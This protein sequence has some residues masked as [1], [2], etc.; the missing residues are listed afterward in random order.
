MK[1][2]FATEHAKE[3][4][5]HEGLRPPKTLTI[6]ITG[7][8]NLACR[9]CWVEAGEAASAPHVPTQTLR[10]LLEEFAAIGG[11]GV[12]L[13][14]GE[15]LCH[16]DWL[17]LIRLARSI[18]FLSVAL[19][20]NAMLLTDEQVAQLRELDFPGLS[21]QVS[22]DGA[23][24]PSH[25]LVRGDGAFEKAM[26]GI[27]RLAG[28][29]LGRRI[30]IAFT[31]MRHNLEEF[32]ALLELA[33]GLGV[34]SVV[35]GTLITGGRAGETDL[36]APADRDQYLRLLD[37]Y[38][39]D[40]RFRDL[41]D[42]L[43]T[44]AALEWSRGGTP[45]GECCTFVENPYLTPEGRLYPCLLCHTDAYAVAGVFG[46][47]LAAALAEGAPSWAALLRISRSRAE[48]I[49]ECQGCP[50]RL[51]CAGGCMGRAW[52]SCGDLMAADDRC[53]LRQTIYRT[54]KTR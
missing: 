46:K 5:R 28:A 2:R 26:A 52:G 36:L 17:E 4:L 34:G 23:E 3:I 21:I 42:A 25:D 32:P 33:A 38:A 7:V 40:G 51:V 30:S 49:P 19:Q 10:R 1:E 20:T 48:S 12:R 15:P 18:G 41:Y 31:E 29:G 39:A 47:D 35:T 53:G 6:A 43:G 37:R 11:T 14:G 16:P 50:G 54:V 13:T 8:C 24:A 44:M 22:L 9:H 45:R 27:R